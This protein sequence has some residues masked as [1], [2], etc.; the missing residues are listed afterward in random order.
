M[1]FLFTKSAV[2]TRKYQTKVLTWTEP[3]GRS[4]PHSRPY[5]SHPTPPSTPPHLTSAEPSET[6]HSTKLSNDIEASRFKKPV[7]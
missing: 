1:K 4:L 5:G 7:L 6:F 2:I 3:V